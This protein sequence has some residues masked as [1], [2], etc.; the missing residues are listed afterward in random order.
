MLFSSFEKVFCIQ[1][2][3]F[4][5]ICDENECGRH[6]KKDEKAADVISSG[7]FSRPVMALAL[8]RRFASCKSTL[9]LVQLF[10]F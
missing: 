7:L 9:Y 2:H 6:G 10:S 8:L 3:F 4:S 1:F 5:A